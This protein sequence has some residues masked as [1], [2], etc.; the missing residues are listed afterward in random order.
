MR[1]GEREKVMSQLDVFGPNVIATWSQL[2]A[3]PFNA[4]RER[5]TKNERESRRVREGERES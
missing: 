3:L 2:S 4:L 5:E 1:E